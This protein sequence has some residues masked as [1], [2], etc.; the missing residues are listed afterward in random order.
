MV[1]EFRENPSLEF[2]NLHQKGLEQRLKNIPLDEKQITAM[3]LEKGKKNI[4]PAKGIMK[5]ICL[6]TDIFF[7]LLQ[8]MHTLPLIWASQGQQN[9]FRIVRLSPPL[10]PIFLQSSLWH[11]EKIPL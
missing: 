10:K 8:T 1:Q 4:V 5:E 11:W 9:T 2:S 7:L 3:L 6:F